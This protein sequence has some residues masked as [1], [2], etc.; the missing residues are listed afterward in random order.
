MARHL[1]KHVG[2]NQQGGREPG[3]PG[4]F[5]DGGMARVGHKRAARR[6]RK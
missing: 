6:D 2:P 3:V 5:R 1:L 4:S